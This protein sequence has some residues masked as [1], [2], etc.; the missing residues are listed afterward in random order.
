M[1]HKRSHYNEKASTAT[2][3]RPH[4]SQLGRSPSSNEDPTQ[5]KINK[6]ILFILKKDSP[7][8][9][10]LPDLIFYSLC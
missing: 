4:L 6:G 3:T 7:L 1:F 9:N 2:K 5:P 8:K 10:N